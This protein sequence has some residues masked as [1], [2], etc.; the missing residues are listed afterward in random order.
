MDNMMR[1]SPA[2]L[3]SS[4]SAAL[5][6]IMN[7]NASLTPEALIAYSASQSNNHNR[8]KSS[9]Q[10]IEPD[11]LQKKQKKSSSRSKE[12]LPP[13]LIGPFG[14]SPVS[15]NQISPGSN[16]RSSQRALTSTPASLALSG[17]R[18]NSSGSDLSN[19]SANSGRS[20]FTNNG[21]GIAL[22]S[23]KQFLKNV[24]KTYLMSTVY[25]QAGRCMMMMMMMK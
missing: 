12:N 3:I 16:G 4:P 21:R 11:L 24:H 6:L 1:V 13:P 22:I 14:N 19:V 17:K 15:R 10:N 5:S 23:L 18:S 8:R 20:V 9:S 7:G 25:L 2:T